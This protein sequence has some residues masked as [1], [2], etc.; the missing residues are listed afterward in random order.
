MLETAAIAFTTFF[1]TVAPVDSALM[2]AALTADS[3]P[4]ERRHMAFRGVAIAT[5]LLLLFAFFGKVLLARLGISLAALTTAG[6]ILLL[7][8]GI[9]LV[10]ARNSGAMS[11][12]RAESREAE[13]RS[14]IS[15]FPLAT[16]LLAGPGTMGAVI[17]IMANAHG[18]WQK[19]AITIAMLL[20]VMLIS[21]V[22]LLM[23]GKL[24]K[25]LGVTGMRVINRVFGVLLC[26]LAVQFIFNGI[27]GS[28][29]LV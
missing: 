1:A 17:L 6:G 11:T 22:L 8:M 16:P 26:S 18:N 19:G 10:F 25:L 7:L 21:L 24:E 9:D 4:K 23:A 28:G 14:D 5:I 20:L 12:T 29:L 15:V 27:R 13:D 2:F 3:T